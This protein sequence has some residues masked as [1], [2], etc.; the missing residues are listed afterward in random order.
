M[1]CGTA[2]AIATLAVLGA[3]PAQACRVYGATGV[4][5]GVADIRLTTAAAQP[6]LIRQFET[7]RDTFGN[8]RFPNSKITLTSSPAQGNATVTRSRI[9]YRSSP[10]A[11]GS[12]TFSYRSAITSGR[13]FDYRVSV[14]IY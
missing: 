4:P 13:T 8:R 10:G 3:S 11:T 12:D 1:K 7:R 14:A 6:C 5:G 2:V 9:V